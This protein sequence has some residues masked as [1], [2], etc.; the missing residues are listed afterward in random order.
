MR[1]S[2]LSS[3]PFLYSLGIVAVDALSVPYSLKPLTTKAEDVFCRWTC[4][5]RLSYAPAYCEHPLSEAEGSAQAHYHQA[6]KSSGSC[7]SSGR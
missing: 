1:L 5:S 2:S 3:P 7:T 6:H 4:I